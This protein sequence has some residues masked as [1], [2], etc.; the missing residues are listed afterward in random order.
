MRNVFH[1]LWRREC[2]QGPAEPGLALA[3]APVRLSR[4]RAANI[5]QS[6]ALQSG[7]ALRRSSEA[8]TPPAIDLAVP[9]FL[10]PPRRARGCRE[11]CE[12]PSARGGGQG[13][14][15]AVGL[16]V[17]GARGRSG[18]QPTNR[19]VPVRVHVRPRTARRVH[20]DRY[21]TRFRLR[22]HPRCLEE[23]QTHDAGVAAFNAARRRRR[24]G[25]G[26]RSRQPCRKAPASAQYR[27]ISASSSAR[28]V[29]GRY[30]VALSTG[31]W[32]ASG[33]R[34]A[35]LVAATGQP[36]H[37]PAASSGFAGLAS[38]SPSTMTRCRRRALAERSSS[39]CSAP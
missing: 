22:Q 18:V 31:P 30:R 6:A 27:V 17:G 25:P 36:A 32:I 14:V 20:E 8:G 24:P 16:K 10:F 29:T 26:C 37:E 33:N 9:G 35:H 39:A 1:G 11:E 34:R 19:S 23:R 38:T 15:G 21:N 7:R 5:D 3:L 28:K 12:H 2:T 4:A 13:G